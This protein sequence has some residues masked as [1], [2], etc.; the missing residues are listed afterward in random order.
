MKFLKIFIFL[1]LT[2]QFSLDSMAKKI[3]NNINPSIQT[4]EAQLPL[5]VEVL[6]L[7]G[8]Y[9]DQAEIGDEVEF[10][11]LEPLNL[12]TEK[13]F[14]PKN[15]IILGKVII[16]KEPG[17]VFQK[18]KIKVVLDTIIYP[19]DYSLAAEG[20]LMA[21]KQ[22]FYTP[23]QQILKI[24]KAKDKLRTLSTEPSEKSI[25]DNTLAFDKGGHS[26]INEG[27]KVYIYLESIG[28]RSVE[29]NVKG[30]INESNQ[31]KN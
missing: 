31:P 26:K 11:V 10:R 5:E 20:Y 15:S 18:T 6:M 25:P 16:I 29:S 24:S 27:E 23:F 19:N 4:Q 14:I 28:F 3:V 2:C 7:K 17:R 21:N 8:L 12:P 13:I 30:E 1:F 9:A 22:K